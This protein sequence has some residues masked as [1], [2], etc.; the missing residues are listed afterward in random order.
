MSS[1]PWLE[2]K[3]KKA[4]TS[5]NKNGYRV[6]K[7]IINYNNE[8]KKSNEIN[9]NMKKINT[10]KQRKKLQYKINYYIALYM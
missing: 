4:M 7:K 2:Y 10:I 8:D 9:K 5:I 3:G 1:V 6:I